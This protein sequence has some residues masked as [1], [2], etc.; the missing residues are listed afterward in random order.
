MMANTPAI[1]VALLL[2]Y[3]QDN[4]W[5]DNLV[6]DWSNWGLAIDPAT[7]V[8]SKRG[9]LGLAFLIISGKFS[10]DIKQLHLVVFMFYGSDSMIYKPT[11]KQQRQILRDMRKLRRRGRL[12]MSFE[13]SDENPDDGEG[14]ELKEQDEQ[15]I[16]AL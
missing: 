14:I 12:E 16:E 15:I 10:F 4:T 3:M 6:S 5:F 13:D 11:P 1:I 2:K 7:Q 8:A 9:R